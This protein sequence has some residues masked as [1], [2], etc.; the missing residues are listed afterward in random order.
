MHVG[1]AGTIPGQ[2]K[3]CR[4]DLVMKT[5]L[6]PLYH[7]AILRWFCQLMAKTPDTK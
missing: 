3:Y 5:F 1:D 2:L 7:S 6:W 4:R